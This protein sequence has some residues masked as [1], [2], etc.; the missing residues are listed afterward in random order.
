MTTVFLSNRL[1]KRDSAGTHVCIIGVGEYPCLVGGDPARLM[2]KPM[3]LGQLSSPPLSA[4]GLANWF[5]GRH[6]SGSEVDERVG[7]NNPN[8][9]LASVEMV[10]SPSSA[11][12]NPSFCGP[13]IKLTLINVAALKRD[14]EHPI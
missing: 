3:G 10:M 11:E 9:P 8:A 13:N 14:S 1:G 6:G 4:V 7:F 2:D 12:T 5:T